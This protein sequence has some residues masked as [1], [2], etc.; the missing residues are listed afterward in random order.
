MS[1][2]AAAHL[3]A[4]GG[5]RLVSKGGAIEYRIRAMTE[6]GIA[7][8]K[9]GKVSE[10]LLGR[11]EEILSESEEGRQLG[12]VGNWSHVGGTWASLYVFVGKVKGEYYGELNLLNGYCR[13]F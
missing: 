6:A 2:A 10:Q 5:R 11:V 7:H 8:D 9:N 13:S 3:L 12:T 1:G 4:R